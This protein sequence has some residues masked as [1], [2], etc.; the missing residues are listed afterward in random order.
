MKK[1]TLSEKVVT[2]VAQH[3]NICPTRLPEP[4]YGIIDPE[5]LDNLFQT[6]QGCVTF[7]YLGYKITVESTGHVKVQNRENS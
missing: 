6:Q 4:L 3:E 2:V 1:Q 7:S 5:A